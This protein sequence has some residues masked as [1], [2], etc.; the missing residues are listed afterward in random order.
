MFQII[1]LITSICGVLTFYLCHKNQRV[2]FRPLPK[3]MKALA[4][5]NVI[6]ALIAWQQVLSPISAVFIWLMALMLIFITIPLFT[7]FK[8]AGAKS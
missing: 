6:L 8:N 1:A 5:I 3:K 4:Y 2:F 7:L